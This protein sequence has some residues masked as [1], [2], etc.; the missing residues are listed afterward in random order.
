MKHA[1][2]CSLF[3]ALQAVDSKEIIEA[4]FSAQKL[5]II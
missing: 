4:I 3:A 1:S 2:V 5:I